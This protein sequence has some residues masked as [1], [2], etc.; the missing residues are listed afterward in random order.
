MIE[1][2][3]PVFNNIKQAVSDD[4]LTELVRLANSSS[5]L[6]SEITAYKNIANPSVIAVRN[7]QGRG[8]ETN[9]STKQITVLT[10]VNTLQTALVQ[11]LQTGVIRLQA[12]A[13]AKLVG[14]LAHELGHVNDPDYP[15]FKY[16]LKDVG[17]EFK[18]LFVAIAGEGKAAFNNYKIYDEVLK[19]SGGKDVIGCG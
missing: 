18:F 17:N 9:P 7:L 11:N 5:L 4:F 2:S 8:G 3:D 13:P 19:Y 16:N 15:K 14:T 6:D 1:I 10:P 12:V